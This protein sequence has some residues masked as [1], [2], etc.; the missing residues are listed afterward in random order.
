M[1]LVSKT[2]LVAIGCLQGAQEAL[3]LILAVG[4]T[5]SGCGHLC[6]LVQVQKPYG[7]H[8]Y[9]EPHMYSLVLF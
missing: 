2:F 9:T 7:T 6:G 3:D 8:F 1:I 4:V 5:G